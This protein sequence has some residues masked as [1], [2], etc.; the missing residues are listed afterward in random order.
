MTTVLPKSQYAKHRGCAPSYITKLIKGG[1]LAFPA[2][3]P[4][5]RID[6]AAADQMLGEAAP[7]LQ[8]PA[9]TAGAPPTA[10]DQPVYAT[11]RARREAAEARLAEIKLATRE[12][13]ILDAEAVA[14]A[15]ELVFTR[16]LQRLQAGVSDLSIPL[17][18]MT[19]PA[20]IADRIAA[21]LR[22]AM[23][24]IHEEF[25][26]DAARRSAA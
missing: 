22:R 15:A 12:G 6:V 10:A 7:P 2:L 17:A 23:A 11:E 13:S 14:V 3:L 1:K 26:T 4:D 20:A 16:A 8:A 18:T 5:G 21:E 25:L 9:S 19:D 24:G